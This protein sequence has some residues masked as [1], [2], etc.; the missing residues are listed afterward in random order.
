MSPFSFSTRRALGWPAPFSSFRRQSTE[1]LD[2]LRDVVTVVKGCSSK[3]LAEAAGPA[4]AP[5]DFCELPLTL[6]PPPDALVVDVPPADLPAPSGDGPLGRFDDVALLDE[7]VGL[8]AVEAGCWVGRFCLA[9]EAHD[10]VLAGMAGATG[11][12]GSR[13]AEAADGVEEPVPSGT[14]AAA[15]G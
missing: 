2:A 8:G 5:V 4:P 12:G 15:G 14:A 10:N 11:F 7:V 3:S 13:V 6:L 9:S 1:R